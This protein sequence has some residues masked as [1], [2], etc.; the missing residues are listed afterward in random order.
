MKD[1]LTIVTAFYDIGRGEIAHN[2]RG[3][4]KYLDYFAFWAGLKNPLIVYT[5]EEFAPLILKM[6]ENL[7]LKDK[8]QI[9]IKNLASFDS[10]M[11]TKMRELMGKFDQTKGRKNPQNIECVSAEYNFLMYSKVLFVC[12]AI[13]RN[14]CTEHIL[15][16]DFGFN[17]KDDFFTKKE[18]FNFTLM[19]NFSLK[20][21]KIALFALNENLNKTH[22]AEIYYNME[23]SL[24]GGLI[25]GKK[26]AWA[27][28]K[29]H[30]KEALRAFL[31][32]QIV[33]DDQILLLW[34]ARNHPNSYNIILNDT[35][36]WFDALSF[37]IPPQIRQNLTH[38]DFTPKIYKI[39]KKHKLKMRENF[40]QKRYF[41][42]ISC[43]FKYLW[44]KMRGI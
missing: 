11:L 10:K 22:L 38:K 40:S 7:G 41:A 42:A 19:P 2:E 14:L 12:D 3:V 16:L 4:Q 30:M 23:V 39:Y 28:F 5:S 8:T 21:D 36:H 35:H 31:S 37:F 26:E 29:R 6:R 25:Y 43:F 15:W 24:M 18:E 44:L 20:N 1:E 34:C 17:H 33:D 13:M 27:K 32:M 9:I